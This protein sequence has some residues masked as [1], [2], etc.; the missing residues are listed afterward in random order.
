MKLPG[1]LLLLAITIGSAN[2]DRRIEI[3]VTPVAA[4]QVMDAT[5]LRR[6]AKNE[7]EVSVVQQVRGP[8][9]LMLHLNGLAVAKLAYADWLQL[10]LPPGR[11]RLGVAPAHNFGRAGLWEMKVDLSGSK[12]RIYRIFQSAG[13]TSSGGNAVYELAPY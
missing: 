6:H 7:V 5:H 9:Q 10:Y 4:S 13:F 3:H 11:Y 1:V 8:G 2:A 12:P